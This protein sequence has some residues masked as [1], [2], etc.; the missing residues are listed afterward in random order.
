MSLQAA[1]WKNNVGDTVEVYVSPK[2][3][4]NKI[5]P[6]IYEQKLRLRIYVTVAPEDGKANEAVIKLLAKELQLPKSSLTIA[7]GSKSRKK[8]IRIVR[9]Q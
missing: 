2:A 9:A 3:S 5:K 6:E 8:V 7:Q 1:D 4:V